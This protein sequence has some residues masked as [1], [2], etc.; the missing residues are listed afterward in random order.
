MAKFKVAHIREQG[1][2]MII[3]PLESSLDIAVATSKGISLKLFRL[4]Q[5]EVACVGRL[6]PRGARAGA[7]AS[8]RPHLGIPFFGA[9]RIERS[10]QTSI[11]S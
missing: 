6:C 3:V 7:S 8:L 2:D 11:E 4:S 1:V 10:S 9:S 5:T